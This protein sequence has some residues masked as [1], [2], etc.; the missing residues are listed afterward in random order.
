MV[1][2]IDKVK[3]KPFAFV[4]FEN[5]EDAKNAMESVNG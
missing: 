3:N 5:H 4:C 2:K 1:V